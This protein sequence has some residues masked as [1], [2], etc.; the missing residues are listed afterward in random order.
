MLKHSNKRAGAHL[1]EFAFVAPIF[2]LFLFGI[3]EYGRM[4]FVRQVMQAAARE[5]ARYAVVHTHDKL[6]A[7]IQARATSTMGGVKDQLGP[8]YLVDVYKCN[9]STGA[10]TGAWDTAGFGDAIAVEITG[11]YK[12][13]LPVY[14]LMPSSINMRA[15]AAMHSEAN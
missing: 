9:P 3:F 15:K 7:D 12:P 1:V 10:N 13:V 4:L 6:K 11:I 8:T 14:L 5:G 2:F